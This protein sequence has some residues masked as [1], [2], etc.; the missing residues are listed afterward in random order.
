M[1]SQSLQSLNRHQFYFCEGCC[2]RLLCLSMA[3]AGLYESSN[4]AKWLSNHLLQFGA[5]ERWDPT[6]RI[7]TMENGA[8]L[9]HNRSI[10]NPD[11]T[12]LH[13]YVSHFK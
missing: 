4:F 9:Q 8:I 12:L 3:V 2:L 13:R 7:L 1:N 10:Q 5:A 11:L 6:S